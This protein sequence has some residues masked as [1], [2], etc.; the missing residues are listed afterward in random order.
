MRRRFGRRGMQWAV[1]V[2]TVGGLLYLCSPPPT[3]A[4]I[5]WYTQ[6][7][8]DNTSQEDNHILNVQQKE[9]EQDLKKLELELKG[10][11]HENFG[12]FMHPEGAVSGAGADGYS[13]RRGTRRKKTRQLYL[14]TNAEYKRVQKVHRE[15]RRRLAD[16]CS[17]FLVTGTHPELLSLFSSGDYFRLAGTTFLP[18][19]VPA[20]NFQMD[21]NNKMLF[22]WQYKVG[23]TAWNAMFARLLNQTSILKSKNFYNMREVMAV[24]NRRD[25]QKALNF[26]RFMIVR[27]PFTRLLSAYRDRFEDTSHSSWQRETFG[28]QI[29]KLTRPS[30][31][32]SEMMT[33]GS[34]SVIP[35]FS[36]F[37]TYLVKTSLEKYDPH[38]APYWKHCAPCI[39]KYNAIGREDTQTEDMRFILEDSGLARKIDPKVLE[40]NANRGRGDTSLLLH[41]Y[42]S[43]LDLD[44]LEALY[45]KYEVDFLLFGYSVEPLLKMLYPGKNIIFSPAL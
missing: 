41:R 38:W 27:D 3:P 43:T 30:L 1:W 6:V 32:E 35:T 15:R 12:K 40:E 44:T 8:T 17:R 18:Q 10:L 16:S 33:N 29:F 14:M 25:L 23:S 24:R 11:K 21:Q 19:A 31:E 42:Y 20:T 39:M 9:L 45:R 34:L 5:S 13:V 4:L 2:V 36:E 28:P 37:V 7:S 22:C 26:Y